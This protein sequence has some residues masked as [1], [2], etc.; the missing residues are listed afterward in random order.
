MQEHIIKG[1]GD[2]VPKAAAAALDILTQAL[3]YR[4]TA[5]CICML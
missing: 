3:W 4:A 1:I 5:W 2:K